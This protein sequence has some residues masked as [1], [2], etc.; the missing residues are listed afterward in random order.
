MAWSQWG[1]GRPSPWPGG[2]LGSNL[3]AARRGGQSL[4]PPK[5]A[6]ATCHSEG[7]R[8]AGLVSAPSHNL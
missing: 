6:G 2:C 5:E 3:V 4:R 1:S 7:E 8:R